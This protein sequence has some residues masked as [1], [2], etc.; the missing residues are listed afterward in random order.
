MSPTKPQTPSR[1]KRNLLTYG[2]IKSF[3]KE[4]LEDIVNVI[5]QFYDD[6]RYWTISSG[7]PM[8]R[9]RECPPSKVLDGPKSVI[10]N[11]EFQLM[12]APNGFDSKHEGKVVLILSVSKLPVAVK[13]VYVYFI[14]FCLENKY[15]HKVTRILVD[16]EQQQ[17]VDRRWR[18]Q[19]PWATNAVDLAD[20]VPFESV[21][22]GYYVDILHIAYEEPDELF[23]GDH[24]APNHHS[25]SKPKSVTKMTLNP[26]PTLNLAAKLPL[27]RRELLCFGLCRAAGHRLEADSVAMTD[28]VAV[29]LRL[30]GDEQS[31]YDA[32]YWTKGVAVSNHVE[33]EWVIGGGV[34]EQM[35]RCHHGQHFYSSNFDG[36]SWC[37]YVSPAGWTA[38]NEDLFSFQL[39]LLQKPYLLAALYA[40]FSLKTAAFGGVA[41]EES[42]VFHFQSC[43]SG[44]SFTENRIE[45]ADFAKIDRM[46]IAVTIDVLAGYDVRTRRRIDP[47]DWEKYGILK[48]DEE[49]S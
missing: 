49:G 40:S 26:A 34:L 4:P 43:R 16:H 38:E 28:A 19:F 9:F 10:Q 36:N 27:D 5:L 7:K 11:I 44:W 45:F 22:F 14:L 37:L 31:L 8:E 12:V 3:F 23:C 2:F 35:Q 33:F 30:L 42:K 21:T 17:S 39:K 48:V 20:L 24:P 32:S 6:M 47:A 13:Y 18:S 46:V 41:I 25:D 29:I 15:Q 1:R